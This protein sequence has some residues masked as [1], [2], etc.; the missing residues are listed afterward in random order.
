MHHHVVVQVPHNPDGADN[1]DRNDDYGE[2]K[3]GQVPTFIGLAVHMQE[4]HEVYHDLHHSGHQ[5]GAK[6]NRM[7][8]GATHHHGERNDRQDD[9]QDKSC[10]VALHAAVRSAAMIGRMTH[11]IAPIR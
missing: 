6:D 7:R 5:N 9:G 1:H 2:D 4:V 8:G 10:H 11:Y 3:C